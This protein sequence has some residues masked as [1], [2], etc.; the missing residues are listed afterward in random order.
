MTLIN[1]L[2]FAT[3]ILAYRII[4][5]QRGRGWFLLGLSV[6]AVFWLQPPLPIRG[7]DFWLPL[8]TLGLSVLGWTITTPPE[9]RAGRENWITAALLVALVLLIA[10]TRYLSLTGLVTPSRPPQ[11]LLVAAIL[12]VLALAGGLLARLTR[13][14]AAG[15]TAFLVILILVFLTLKIPQLAEQ[16]SAGFRS[17]AGQDVARASAIDIRWLGFSYVVFRLMATLR[18]RQTGRLPGMS[19]RDYLTYLI[20][21][22]ALTAGPIDRPERFLKDL[23]GDRPPGAAEYLTGGRRLV[24]GLFKKFV[25]ADALALLALSGANAD[26]IQSPLWLWLAV[27]AYAGLIYFDFSGYTDIAIGLARWL[28]IALPENF[29]HPYLKPNLT[30]FW[31][32]WHMT[33]TQWF[34]AYFFNP[35]TRA[36][37]GGKYPLGAVGVIFITQVSTFLLIGLWHGGTLNFILWGLWHGLG[38][39]IQNRYSD[40]AKPRLAALDAHPRVRR[41]TTVAGTVLTFFFVALGWVWFA[42]PTTGQALQVITRLF[43]G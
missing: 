33:L 35:L 32:N 11:L 41:L 10:A 1:I 36:L 8:T 6:L 21:F 17:W 25:V 7:L 26:Q 22:P 2:I 42:L 30:Q 4:L 27:I 31:N 38:L 18:D 34:R 28:G 15:L 9:N 12:L 13:P 24:V 43:G 23:Q 39:F 29:N 14:A 37:R 19:L 3:L 5:R 20:F 16:L 40:W